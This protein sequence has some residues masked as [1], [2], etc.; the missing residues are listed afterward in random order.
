MA[1]MSNSTSRAALRNAVALAV[2]RGCIWLTNGPSSVWNE[3]VPYGVL[4]EATVLH[5]S[6]SLI[7]AQNLTDQ[8]L[9]AEWRVGRVNGATP[10][11]AL[12]QARRTPLPWGLVR[13]SVKAAVESRWLQLVD[14][15]GA[16]NCSYDQAGNAVLERPE[17]INHSEQRVRPPV[18]HRRRRRGSRERSRRSS[19]NWGTIAAKSWICAGSRVA[20]LNACR[21]GKPR[22]WLAPASVETPNP[23]QTHRRT[24]PIGMSSAVCSTTN[25]ISSIQMQTTI[26]LT[27][28]P[29]PLSLAPHSAAPCSIKYFGR[30]FRMVNTIHL[31]LYE[32]L[33]SLPWTDVFST[34]YDTIIERSCDSFPQ[35]KYTIVR[36]EENL[37]YSK[38]ARIVKL[39]GTL[40][41]NRDT[42]FS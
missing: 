26:I 7:P 20:D 14:G 33:F 11:R 39:H 5:P 34:N 8:A 9:A 2:E 17:Q 32:S 28:R 3:P 35:P 36:T 24:F 15:S 10:T 19:S 29:S 38:R 31:K 41:D 4:D 22:P 18:R 40:D 30:K 27:Y 42:P 23:A 16:L 12:S 25:S 37:V 21:R 13:A 6:P 1:T